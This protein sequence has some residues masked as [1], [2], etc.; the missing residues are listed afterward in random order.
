MTATTKEIYKNAIQLNPIDR[1]ELI[2]KLFA[3]FNGNSDKPIENNIKKELKSRV[4]AYDNGK[5]TSD[6]MENVF[7]R[8]SKLFL[9]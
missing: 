9:Q 1:A 8:L 4:S 5:I 2:E 3:S 7:E 6:S